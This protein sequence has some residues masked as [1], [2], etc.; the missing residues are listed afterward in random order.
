[1]YTDFVQVNV[2][3]VQNPGTLGPFPTL[4]PGHLHR[5]V[6]ITNG[7]LTCFQIVI[8]IMGDPVSK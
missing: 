5:D 4:R 6:G 3:F 8:L 7:S 2:S 1:M